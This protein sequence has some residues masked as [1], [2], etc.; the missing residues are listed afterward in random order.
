MN[1]AKDEVL[2]TTKE[3]NL[4]GR[5][6]FLEGELL[7]IKEKAKVLSR[8]PPLTV[9]IDAASKQLAQDIVDYIS[10]IKGMGKFT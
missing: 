2:F 3:E 10:D 8:V 1:D 7:A 4:K 9:R 6:R 5:I